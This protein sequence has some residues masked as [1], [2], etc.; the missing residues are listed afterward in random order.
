M[1]TWCETGSLFTCF[2]GLGICL[3]GTGGESGTTGR[4]KEEKTDHI[5]TSDI[6][7]YI[8]TQTEEKREREKKHNHVIN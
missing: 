7:I 4:G 8:N 1:L 5:H 6:Y 3:V 2:L